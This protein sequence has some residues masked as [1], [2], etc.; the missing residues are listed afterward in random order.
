MNKIYIR[1][2][3][4]TLFLLII[5]S[6]FH[7]PL[8]LTNIIKAHAARASKANDITLFY[9]MYLPY[10]IKP[11]PEIDYP[12]NRWPHNTNQTTTVTYIW[13]DNIIIYPTWYDAFDQ[14]LDS[15]DAAD[16]LINFDYDLIL[17]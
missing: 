2:L 9:S 1:V 14:G 5:V 3:S 7:L 13:K 12:P 11:V 8:R 17:V 6:A 16:T 4:I 15:W 10:L